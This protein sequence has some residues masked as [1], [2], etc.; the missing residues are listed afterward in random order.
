MLWSERYPAL[1][2]A[3]SIVWLMLKNKQFQILNDLKQHLLKLS[4]SGE[5]GEDL[6]G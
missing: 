3:N 2:V 6:F 4:C 5:H 1:F